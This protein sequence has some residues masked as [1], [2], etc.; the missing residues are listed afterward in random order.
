MKRYITCSQVNDLCL[1]V[2]FEYDIV[3]SDSRPIARQTVHSFGRDMNDCQQKFK[4]Y[5][6]AVRKYLESWGHSIDNIAQFEPRTYACDDANYY[7][8][9]EIKDDFVDEEGNSLAFAKYLNVDAQP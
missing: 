7:N 3:G 9:K 4:K 6:I 8:Y 2:E 5:A 1:G